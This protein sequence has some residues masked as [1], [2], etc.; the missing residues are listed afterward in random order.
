M[1]RSLAASLATAVTILGSYSL[2][3][4]QSVPEPHEAVQPSQ[5]LAGE[6]LSDR[7]TDSRIVLDFKANSDELSKLVPG[8]WDISE[9]E[10]GA[11]KGA[12]LQVLFYDRV[13]Q[14]DGK[15]KSMG[16]PYR[17]VVLAAN[18]KPH[19]K[20]DTASVVFKIFADSGGERVP[21]PYANGVLATI[22]RQ[23]A[24]IQKTGSPERHKEEWLV[25][26]APRQSLQL[27]MTWD[28]DQP[29]RHLEEAHIYSSVK[30]DFYRIYRP[31]A[32]TEIAKSEADGINRIKAFA[33][34]AKI[35]E[36]APLFKSAR[37]VA[38]TVDPIY[39]RDVFLPNKN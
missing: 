26:S 30:T 37:L 16:A 34:S 11:A 13:T 31:D 21:G 5:S 17:F 4:A 15:N 9:F 22:E 8:P 39:V 23:I 36:Y 3:Y 38:V 25:Q 1:N 35:P 33:F 18:V 29:V 19:G 28:A 20:P 10:T 2:A 32:V 6:T 12:N 24:I 27:R 14:L 7:V